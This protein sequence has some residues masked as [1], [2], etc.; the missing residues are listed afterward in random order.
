MVI[1]YGGGIAEMTE[2]FVCVAPVCLG[3]YTNP[4]P[5]LC[6]LLLEF[7]RSILLWLALCVLWRKIDT[8]AMTSSVPT[9]KSG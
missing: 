6:C 1:D 9:A 2:M 3:N 8:V 4:T 7:R 5:L